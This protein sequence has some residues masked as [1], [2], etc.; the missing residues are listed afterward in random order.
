[1]GDVHA[2]R[3]ALSGVETR[4]DRPILIFAGTLARAHDIA[5][6]RKL[7]K[8]EWRYV[9]NPED[10]QAYRGDDCLVLIAASTY[11]VVEIEAAV[12]SRGLSCTFVGGH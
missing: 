2:L 8:G 9:R 4:P 10:L 3:Q 6:D 7:K 12:R 1:M 11:P 5:H